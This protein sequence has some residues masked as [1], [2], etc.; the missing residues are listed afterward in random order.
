MGDNL[1]W[2]MILRAAKKHGKAAIL[3]DLE[4]HSRLLTQWATM[5]TWGHPHGCPACRVAATRRQQWIARLQPLS[6]A[7]IAKALGG[8]PTNS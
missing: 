5:P 7:D 4:N 1:T 6:D 3:T 2:R 8:K